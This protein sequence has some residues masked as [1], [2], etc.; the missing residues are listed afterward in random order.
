M[1]TVLFILPHSDKLVHTIKQLNSALV[2]EAPKK[3]FCVLQQTKEA[4]HTA[5]S[6]LLFSYQL[7]G[8]LW[9]KNS[10]FHIIFIIIW[11]YTITLFLSRYKRH[12]RLS[13]MEWVDVTKINIHQVKIIIIIKKLR[14]SVNEK[15]HFWMKI[16]WVVT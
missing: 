4:A 7:N 11:L 16:E 8:G 10:L 14:E 5:L 9:K 1:L 6:L 3:I 13:R 2:I 15:V 12:R